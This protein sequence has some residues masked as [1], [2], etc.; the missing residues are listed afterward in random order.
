MRKSP[1]MLL[2]CLFFICVAT[3]HCAALNSDYIDVVINQDSLS[4]NTILHSP[5][6]NPNLGGQVS[7]RQA[8][9]RHAPR[10]SFSYPAGFEKPIVKC[11]PQLCPPPACMP[12]KAPGCTLPIR[13]QGQIELATQ[14]F[15][16]TFSGVVRTQATVNGFPG[17]DL[18]ATGDLGLP[19]NNTL[20]EY[21]A[22]CQFRPHWALFYS[23]MPIH[24]K[25]DGVL[26][27]PAYIGGLLYGAGTHLKTKWDFLYQKA[28]LM[29]QPIVNCGAQVSIYASWIY[30]DQK[31]CVSNGT[32]HT[33]QSTVDRTRNMVAG[34]IEIQR[35]IRTMCNGST[36][37]SDCRGGVSF[38][39]GAFGVDA[40]TSLRY[41]VPLGMNRWGYARGGYRYLSLTEDRTDLR[42]DATFYGGFAELGMIF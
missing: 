13:R 37:S 33:A 28:G 16:A 22:R 38:L 10:T 15:W 4:S 27:K 39:D 6:L 11:G 12:M 31:Q 36:L 7:Y 41:S 5:S 19:I 8:T 29:Y 40:Q 1:Y 21:S 20:L 17:T 30:N 25:G 34:G 24:M 42:L 2:V 23:V 18:D 3:N 35:C 14:V 26:T 9:A 32:C